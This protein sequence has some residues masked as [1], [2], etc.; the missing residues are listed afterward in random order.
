MYGT[1]DK[2]TKQTHL[3][4]KQSHHCIQSNKLANG[5]NKTSWGGGGGVHG[6]DIPVTPFPIPTVTVIVLQCSISGH[7]LPYY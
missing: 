2:L 3:L 5:A 7:D 6:A 4:Y 1:A